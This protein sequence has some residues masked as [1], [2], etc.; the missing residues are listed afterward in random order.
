MAAL[1]LDVDY[2]HGAESAVLVVAVDGRRGR[3]REDLYGHAR[4]YR[5]VPTLQA[6]GLRERRMERLHTSVK[7][8]DERHHVVLSPRVTRGIH[9]TPSTCMALP[10]GGLDAALLRSAA[11][12]G[13][14]SSSA[15]SS[16][17]SVNEAEV[18]VS[19]ERLL[20]TPSHAVNYTVH[21][22]SS[23]NNIIGSVPQPRP[24]HAA[25]VP[26][27]IDALVANVTVH[28]SEAPPAGFRAHLVLRPSPA[29]SKHGGLLS[30]PRSSRPRGCWKAWRTALHASVDAMQQSSDQAGVDGTTTASTPLA[31]RA[32]A[33]AALAQWESLVQLSGSCLRFL[34]PTGEDESTCL[35]DD[36]DSDDDVDDL[37]NDHAERQAD[38][39]IV[40]HKATMDDTP[41]MSPAGVSGSTSETRNTPSTW[42]L[43]VSGRHAI[44]RPRAVLEVGP[45]CS[46][47][48]LVGLRFEATVV[49]FQSVP[50]DVWG[51][52]PVANSSQTGDN[53]PS[54]GAASSDSTVA[55][56]MAKVGLGEAAAE[57]LCRLSATRT[58]LSDSAW[59]PHHE[60]GMACTPLG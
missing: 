14:P 20:A 59:A 4:D 6:L 57:R 32:Q 23:H 27:E 31:T 19:P 49:D 36:D 35:E 30:S 33:E 21:I 51:S 56:C 8:L 38:P 25:P 10:L 22:S 2:E 47:I 54:W 12:V 29:H 58:L 39:A 40:D 55:S 5:V 52:P 44:P 43:Q 45:A 7:H 1:R 26:L 60:V 53:E 50:C 18:D 28:S 48:S 46:P 42:A 17:V 34:P 3:M 15:S 24:D 41:S 13:D 9:Q 16:S 37:R 11:R